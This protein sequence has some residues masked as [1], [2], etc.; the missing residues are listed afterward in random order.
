MSTPETP[1]SADA[2]YRMSKRSLTLVVASVT[3]VVVTCIAFLIPVPY[4]TMRPGPAFNTLGDFDDKPMIE[5]G[6]GVETYKTSGELNFTTVSVSRADSKLSLARAISVYFDGDAA[7][8]PRSLLYPDHQSQKDSS[9]EAAAQLS[10]SKQT[11]EVAALTAAGFKVTT[12]PVVG[13]VTKDSPADGNLEAGDKIL[14]VDGTAVSEPDAIATAIANRKPGAPVT[15]K[16]ERA[17]A[18]KDVTFNTEA[19]KH[20][21]SKARVGIT[22][23]ADY[24][25]PI[26]ITNNVGNSIGGPSAGTMFALAI[27]DMLTPGELTGGTSIAGTGEMAADGTVGAIGGIRQKMAGA[28]EAGAKIF[29]APA[30][31]CSEAA[32]GDDFGLKVVKIATLDSAIDSLEKLAK[33]PKAAVP[34]C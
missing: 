10:G 19:G 22:L 14:A 24:D 33:D 28:S 3:L 17:G 27:Y 1:G 20:D 13:A 34:S 7:V 16:I 8:V 30:P 23:G 25:L 12:V 9:A 4:A 32:S 31:N 29:L 21:P 15:I 2:P 6:K 26:D 18:S 5:F 11:S